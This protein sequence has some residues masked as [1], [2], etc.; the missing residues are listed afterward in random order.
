PLDRALR[1]CRGAFL[2]RNGVDRADSGEPGLERKLES[3]KDCRRLGHGNECIP[4]CSGVTHGDRV[5]ARAQDWP[6]FWEDA[7]SNRSR[8]TRPGHSP[9]T[10]RSQA[11][12]R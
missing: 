7:T 2:E 8:Q 1:E 5:T 11:R 12:T 6:G 3:A 4:A 9:R 10:T